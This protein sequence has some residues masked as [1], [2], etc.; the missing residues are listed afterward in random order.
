MEKYGKEAVLVKLNH[1]VVHMLTKVIEV[2]HEATEAFFTNNKQVANYIIENDIEINQMENRIEMDGLSCL[3]LYQPEAIDL[4]FVVGILKMI[5]DIERIGDLAVNI[6]QAT[7]NMEHFEEEILLEDL[8][9]LVRHTHEML[10]K[11]L[12]AF[13]AKDIEQAKSVLKMDDL[14]DGL[15]QTIFKESLI[16]MCGDPKQVKH[17]IQYLL[18]SRHLE[19]IGD[20]TTNI[21]EHTIFIY[22]GVNV[23]H[24]HAKDD[25][26]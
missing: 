3:A 23:K 1:D 13:N 9:G 11:A 4:R 15:T 21:A 10:E 12:N 24:F 16:R 6:A 5:T 14:L 19:R 25:Y 8:H 18:I 7:I 26:S 17:Y 2:I 22:G 20:H